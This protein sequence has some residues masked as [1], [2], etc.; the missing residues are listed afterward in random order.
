MHLKPS[1]LLLLLITA[2]LCASSPQA[3]S[4]VSQTALQL[5]VSQ[6][7]HQAS[8]LINEQLRATPDDF[9]ALYILA[10][11]EQTR[12]L[13]YESYLV[14]GKRFQE[15]ADSIRKVLE[16]RLPNLKGPDSLR[17][18][19]Y[20]ANLIGGI[21]IMQA[22]SGNWFDGVKNA[23]SSVG[24]LKQVKKE[25]P[26]F[27]AADLG[28]GAFDYYLSTSLK[29][30]PFVTEDKV[31]KGV[32]SIEKALN[33]PFPFNHAAKN[34]LSWI[35]IDR[36]KFARA[37]SL[38]LSVLTDLPDNT[39]FLR[40]RALIALWTGRYKDALPMAERLITLSESRS[41][42]NWSDLVTGYYIIVNCYEQASKTEESYASAK[43]VLSLPIPAEYKEIP[44]LK[45]HLKYL[46]EIRS[47]NK[48]V[49][50]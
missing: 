3:E 15:L 42:V 31:E 14:D 18:L 22:K 38:A 28:I 32:E 11:I 9:D 19:F 24:I 21:G 16:T 12:I 45:R 5:M 50:K 36:K 27:L 46:S 4:K 30:L 20:T 48:P 39:I 37:D 8:E 41:P 2:L 1:T 17:C 7:Y 6:K 26:N 43:K 10:T 25:D 33:A 23:V 49:K 35:L 40:I 47:K 34:T 13:D 29:W 44:H